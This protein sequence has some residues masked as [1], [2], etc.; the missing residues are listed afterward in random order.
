MSHDAIVVGLGTMGSAAAWQLTA[1]GCSVLGLDRHVPP[2]ALG[3]AHGRSRIIRTAYMEDPAYVPLVQR[4]L[5]LWLE[6]EGMTEQTLLS[7]ASLL[8]IGLPDSDAVA[9]S[10]ASARAHELPHELLDAGEVRRR[11][12]VFQPDDDLAAFYEEVAGV[13]KPE[14]CVSACLDVA[15]AAGAD[16]RYGEHVLS[17]N[18]ESDGVRVRTQTGEY[19]AKSLIIT[20]GAWASQ[21]LP[22]LDSELRVERQVMHW[23]EPTGDIDAFAPDRLPVYLWESRAGPVIYGLPALDGARGGV[24]VALHHGGELTTADQLDRTVHEADVDAV[25]SYL[26]DRIPTLNGRWLEGAVCM[27]TNTPDMHFVIGPH[28]AEEGVFIAAGFSGHGF[29]FAP[30]VGEVL[31]D[32][33]VDG[34]TRQ[35]V[36]PFLPSRLG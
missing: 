5:E 3:S 24:K 1:R 22:E 29:K 21:L 6:L 35:P 20:M 4:S 19:L 7:P 16:L 17:W 27:Y 31:T 34:F 12:P 2:H 15:S 18:R 25:R 33:V 32:L 28:P 30:V 10:L 13:L 8:M 14:A 11:F 26:V 23:F 9:G 36:E